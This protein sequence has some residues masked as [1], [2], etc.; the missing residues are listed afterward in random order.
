MAWQQ[1]PGHAEIPWRHRASEQLLPRWHT[2]ADELLQHV[3]AERPRAAAVS[4]LSPAQERAACKA[5]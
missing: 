3:Y 2:A 1:Q 4:Y 5:R